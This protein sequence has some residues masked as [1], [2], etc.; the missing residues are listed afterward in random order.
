MAKKFI[1]NNWGAKPQTTNVVGGQ[2]K[3]WSLNVKSAEYDEKGNL[4]LKIGGLKTEDVDVVNKLYPNIFKIV[5]GE[6]FISKFI[7]NKDKI[8][9]FDSVSDI[10]ENTLIQTKH[11]VDSS[12]SKMIDSIEKFIATTPTN[13]EIE[14]NDDGTFDILDSEVAETLGFGSEIYVIDVP[15]MILFWDN[16]EGVAYN[17]SDATIP[18]SEDVNN[19]NENDGNNEEVE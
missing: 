16:N 11:Y 8:S 18:D 12:V 6:K 14:A 4:I 1:R 15:G 13:D 3:L 10:L 5:P 19:E 7:I 17:W 2:N 9:D